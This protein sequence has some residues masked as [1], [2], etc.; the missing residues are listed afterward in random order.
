MLSEHTTQLGYEN[1]KYNEYDLIGSCGVGYTRKGETFYFDL[2]DYD[3]IKKYCWS[4]NKQGYLR[5]NDLTRNNRVIFMH[6]LLCKCPKGMIPDHYNRIKTDNRKVN[7]IPSTF[8]EN[9]ANKSKL[10]NNTS[11]FT[12]VSWHKKTGKWRAYI[13]YNKKVISLG[14]FNDKKEAVIARL[15]AEKE[16]FKEKAPQRHLFKEYGIE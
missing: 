10:S 7:L 2:E 16:Y 5:A 3:K 15:K 8:S 11:G 1:K 12:G 14:V 4:K 13:T 6:Q 9:M